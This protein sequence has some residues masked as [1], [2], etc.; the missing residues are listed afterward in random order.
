MVMPLFKT[1]A[2]YEEPFMPLIIIK[3]I[4]EVIAIP[5]QIAP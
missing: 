5:P 4:I 1:C 2:A 3:Y